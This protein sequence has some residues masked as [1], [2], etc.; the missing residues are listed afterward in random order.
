LRIHDDG[1]HPTVQY[2]RHTQSP[3]QGIT[4]TTLERSPAWISDRKNH[5]GTRAPRAARR[6]GFHWR[7]VIPDRGT[8]DGTPE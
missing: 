8:V 4:Q 3:Y 7:D 5:H 2:S 6:E 1:A